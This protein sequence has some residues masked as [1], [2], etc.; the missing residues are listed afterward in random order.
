MIGKTIKYLRVKKGFK[1]DDLARELGIARTTLSGYEL[2]TR[3]TSFETMEKIADKCG[4]DIYFVNKKD[5][6]K[7]KMSDLE[8]K[9]I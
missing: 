4:Y 7:F 1:Q 3:Q 2:E 6:S 5:S 8:R 9:D